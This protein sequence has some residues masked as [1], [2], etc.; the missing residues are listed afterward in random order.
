MPKLK[1]CPH[2]GS[3]ARF[4]QYLDAKDFRFRI[5]VV[6]TNNKCLASS[7]Y[8]TCRAEVVRAWNKRVGESE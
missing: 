4:T 3:K 6:C 1:P 2:C 8:S 5:A 7:G